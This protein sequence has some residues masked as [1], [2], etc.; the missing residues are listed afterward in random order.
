M[1]GR[2]GRAASVS[3]AGGAVARVDVGRVVPSSRIRF[4]QHD[5]S[6]MRE[7]NS[8]RGR[9]DHRATIGRRSTSGRLSTSR[10]G[11]DGLLFHPFAATDRW[12]GILTA[13]AL[14]YGATLAGYRRCALHGERSTVGHSGLESETKK[15]GY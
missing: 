13:K 10:W 9:N 8:G 1:A 6:E 15:K 12:G 7:R 3:V 11:R 4:L 5:G 2:A 14:G